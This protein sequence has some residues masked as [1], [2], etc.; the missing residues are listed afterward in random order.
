MRESTVRQVSL[1][2]GDDTVLIQ[3]SDNGSKRV[4]LLQWE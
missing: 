3:V 4:Q 1:S 2:E